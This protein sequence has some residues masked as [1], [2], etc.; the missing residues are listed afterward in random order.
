MLSIPLLRQMTVGEVMHEGIVTCSASADLDQ[1]AAAMADH[2]IHCVVAIDEGP[3]RE[4]DDH[5]W[6]VVS[7]LD[8]MRGIE[9][10]MDLDAGNLAE[11]DVATVA[12]EDTLDRAARTMARRGL[13]HLV[14]IADDR[15]VGVI[16]TL[17]IARAT[18][19]GSFTASGTARWRPPTR[20]VLRSQPRP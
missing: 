19:N 8:L 18:R 13:A 20:P 3:A 16:S 5:L 11:L 10:G 9:S 2:G 1:V 15:P 17:D 7:D 4:D 14:V 12:R 6:G